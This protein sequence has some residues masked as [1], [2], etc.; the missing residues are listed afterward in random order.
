MSAEKLYSEI[1]DEFQTL[2]TEDEQISLLRKNDHKRFRD[3]LQYAFNKKIKFDVAIPTY[4]PAIEPAGMNFTYL[5]MEMHKLYRFIEGH[6]D[7]SPNL[8]AEKQTTLL[9]VVLECLHKD[10]ASLLVK[11]MNKDLEIPT[12]TEKLIKKAFPNIELN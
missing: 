8:T 4:R 10:E 5:D 3:F 7:R 2:T 11:M 9:A 6:P 12:L 1:L